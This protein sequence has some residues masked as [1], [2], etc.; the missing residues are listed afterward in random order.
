MQHIGLIILNGLL[1]GIQRHVRNHKRAYCQMKSKI[2]GVDLFAGAGGMS[3]GAENAGIDVRLAI[4]K[5]VF[6][7]ATY[8]ANHPNTHV[9]EEDIKKVK[10]IPVNVAKRAKKILFGGPPCQGFSMSNTR[11]RSSENPGNWLFREF[12]RI[13]G[14]WAPDWVVLENVKGIEQLDQGDFL[15][16]IVRGFRGLG[17]ACSWFTL[18]A[19]DF[20]VPQVRNRFFLIGSKHGIHLDAPQ[21][22]C[23]TA[24]TVKEAILDL[25][26]LTNGADVDVL[27]YKENAISPYAKQMRGRCK[28]CSGHLVSR[29][30]A[31]V[32]K[33]YSY[34]PQGG[35]WVNIPD[36][37]M[38]SYA[39]KKR[40]HTGI[41]KRLC[42]D[43]TS[44]VLGNY[45]KN[46]LIHP[47][48]DRGLSVR[49]AARLQSFP[50]SYVFKGNLGAKQQ[51]VGN[52]VPPKL[53]EAV[54]RNI[55][56]R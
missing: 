52:A 37:L 39:D 8:K 23:A 12:I 48:E 1:L 17:Y 55:I 32:V 22:P 31:L 53:A 33:R 20:G 40:C 38:G 24:V 45:R 43:S 9:L 7:A 27:P 30:S 29:N 35:N 6:A 26:T 21:K 4:E 14:I 18:N 19:A 50:D 42:E 2:I 25:P 34:V 44:V 54:F 49:E 16:K 56:G 10:I 46:M 13:A 3:L 36:E 51:Q 41:Y 11:T 5:D 28:K 15:L 47:T